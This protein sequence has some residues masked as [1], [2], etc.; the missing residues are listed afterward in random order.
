MND[1]CLV[2]DRRLVVDR[3]YQTNDPLIM[4]ASPLTKFSR[5]YHAEQW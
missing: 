3:H 1:A 5:Q 2:F 4:A